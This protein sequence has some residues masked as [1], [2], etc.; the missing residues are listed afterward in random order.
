ME[1][2][3]RKEGKIKFF[4]PYEEKLTKKNI[5]FFNP[6]MEVSRDIS[7]AVAKVVNPQHFFD[8]L[9]GS[10]V[11]GLRIAEEVGCSV[12]L[13]DSNPKAVELIKKNAE[14]N[15]I[16]VAVRNMDANLLMM[17]EKY[18]F[19][20]IDPFGPPVKFLCSAM[21]AVRDKGILAVT[22]TDT[23]ALCGTYPQACR[24]KY[25]S[26]SLRTDYYNELGLRILL[27]Y[28]ARSALR[29]DIGIQ[30]LFSHCTRHYF[31][32]YVRVR[33]S[34][35]AAN[36]TLKNI[37]YVSHCFKCLSRG[38]HTL[39]EIQPSCLCGSRLQSAGPLWS[40][41]FADTS[42]CA[43]LI[44]Q[45]R[46]ESFLRLNEEMKLID[47]IMGEQDITLPY[48]DIH[49]FFGVL[50]APVL[51]FDEIFSRLR[52]GGFSVARTHFSGVGI[53]TNASSCDLSRI[54]RD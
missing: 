24:R 1:L 23:S 11:R 51:S 3:V 8:A 6:H 54:L 26:V 9:A 33:R 10:G 25:D 37:L 14:L 22:A 50:G 28:V 48:Y 27:G 31:R 15:S 44:Q 20:D 18:D 5:V 32:V 46:E 13:N 29:Y 49:K 40:A 38:Y 12:T 39:S 42:F 35:K 45:L 34:R 53:R 30:P 43:A 7:V 4:V 41:A 36:N 17:Q 21:K 16:E 47:S 52:G 2:V 19:V